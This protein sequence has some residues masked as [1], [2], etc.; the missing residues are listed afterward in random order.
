[1]KA[2]FETLVENSR[3]TYGITGYENLT[4]LIMDSFRFLFVALH[5]LCSMG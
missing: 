4:K 3:V 2:T 5:L 1:M